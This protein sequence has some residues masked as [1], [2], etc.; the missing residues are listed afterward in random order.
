VA[1][2]DSERTGA[3][4]VVVDVVDRTRAGVD[5]AAA[6]DLVAHVLRSEGVT[7]A[8]VGV[9][10][11]GERRIRALNREYRGVDAVTD[12]LSFPLEEP[13]E[14]PPVGVPRLLGDVVV[15]PVQARRQ[16]VA[17]GAPPARELAVLLVHGVLHLLGWEH[18]D[19]ETDAGFT[20]G[21]PAPRTDGGRVAPD[22]RARQLELLEDRDWEG[23]L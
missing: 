13:G 21:K 16:A 9:S 14:R 4:P 12:V 11:V 19:A 7:A 1:R 15:C 23:L 5:A 17:D 10:F 22:M 18:G 8:E 6:T 20:S 2:L 3:G